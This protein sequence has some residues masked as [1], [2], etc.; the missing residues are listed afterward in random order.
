MSIPKE[1]RALMIQLMYLV[2]T[3][4]LALNITREVLN[5]FN[6]INSSIEKS[7]STIDEK[8][9]KLYELFDL[10]EAKPEERDKVKPWN[11]KA[12][13][14]RKLSEEMIAYLAQ[15]KDTVIARGGGLIQD[16]RTGEMV[17]AKMEDINVSTVYFVEVEKKG[18]ELKAKLQGY[19]DQ[20]LTYID[21]PNEKEVFKSQ[22]PIDLADYKPNDDN[23]RGD[24]ATGTFNHVPV[25]GAVTLLSKFQNDVKNAEGFILERLYSKI[26][27]EDIH[28]DDY[29]VIAVPNI[30]YALAGDEITTTVTLA[31]YSKSIRP[32]ISSSVGGPTEVKDGIG[33]IKFR[34]PN[35]PGLQTVRGNVTVPIRGERKSYPFEFTYMV[36]STGASLGLD[37]MNVFYIGVDNPV[38]VSA[39]GYNIE[40]IKL[41]IP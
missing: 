19:I 24:W 27:A 21:D 1:P 37:K 25:I 12:K 40:D 39:S 7:N 14:V 17:P 23:P 9:A 32:E 4:M 8:N 34:A 26:H 38:T 20:L 10:A 28:I 18:D 41:A 30:S 15:L 2:L 36:G 5:A 33:I 6:T 22:I 29:K 16:D 13:E 31:A 35:S 11:D 3:A